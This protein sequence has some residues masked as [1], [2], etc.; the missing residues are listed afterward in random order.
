MLSPT[1]Q[2]GMRATWPLYPAESTPCRN[3]DETMTLQ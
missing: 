3:D 1:G 2:A